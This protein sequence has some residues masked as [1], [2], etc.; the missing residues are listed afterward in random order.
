MGVDTVVS[1]QI[2]DSVQSSFVLIKTLQTDFVSENGEELVEV[3]AV[4]IIV[5]DLLLRV[6]TLLHIDHANLQLRL[7]KHLQTNDNK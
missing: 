1:S 3:V 2:M 7:D 6:L 4:L 5:Q